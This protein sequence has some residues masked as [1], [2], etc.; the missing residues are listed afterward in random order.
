MTVAELFERH[1][2]SELSQF[3]GAFQFL[4]EIIQAGEMPDAADPVVRGYVTQLKQYLASQGLHEADDFLLRFALVAPG[5][6]RGIHPPISVLASERGGF[7]E[8]RLKEAANQV[9]R[10]R[11]GLA[12]GRQFFS[13]LSP[14]TAIALQEL[15]GRSC[16]PAISDEQWVAM[17]AALSLTDAA[18]LTIRGFKC[19]DHAAKSVRDGWNLSATNVSRLPA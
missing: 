4:Q 2:T 17:H 7:S 9:C 8:R 16:L 13:D 10:M 18:E 6:G 15:S 1:L 3:R 19:I 5:A 12:L 11:D 14:D